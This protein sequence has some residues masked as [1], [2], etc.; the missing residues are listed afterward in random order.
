MRYLIFRF[1]NQYSEPPVTSEKIIELSD[2]E[3][4]SSVN[5]LAN[6]KV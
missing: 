3:D 2:D 5:S 6:K 1:C 4:T